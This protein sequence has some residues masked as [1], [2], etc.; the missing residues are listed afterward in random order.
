[1][2]ELR[3]QLATMKAEEQAGLSV[4]WLERLQKQEMAYELLGYVRKARGEAVRCWELLLK[5]SLTRIP[6]PPF[7]V[8]RCRDRHLRSGV[9]SHLVMRPGLGE[10]HGL[11]DR[12]A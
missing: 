6:R 11:F 10:R 8:S 5:R 9:S 4:V 12:G 1:M 2:A 7:S 3:Q